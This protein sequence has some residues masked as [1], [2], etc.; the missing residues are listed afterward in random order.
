MDL[1]NGQ[2]EGVVARDAITWSSS[3]SRFESIQCR[4]T[5]TLDGEEV[6]I[7]F[8][9]R[10]WDFIKVT[11]QRFYVHE[12]L[13]LEQ[14]F[15]QDG[16]FEQ[17]YSISRPNFYEITPYYDLDDVDRDGYRN[18]DD[19]F[20]TNELE[21]LDSD[22]D[23]V[24]D[25]SDPDA[26]GVDT[27]GDGVPDNVDAF[28]N[29]PNE[30]VDADGDGIGANTDLND[31]DPNI[32]SQP[33]D[34]DADGLTDEQESEIGTDPNSNDSDGDGLSDGIEVELGTNPLVQ[35]TD[36]DGYTDGEEH[37]DGTSPTDGDEM[38]SAG[39]SMMLL[40]AAMDA[41][42]ARAP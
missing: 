42:A 6:C 27:D 24:G 19:A 5:S 40:K 20:P 41:A 9:K 30:S 29:D 34:S 22:G 32:G 8:Q 10:V 35:D 14:D 31:N 13:S 39:M 2:L 33:V 37:E 12:T 1:G 15:D 21:W 25:N 36:N 4:Q 16:Q 11:D 17:W 3:G 23:G 7:Y 26:I 18:D 38:P 28:P